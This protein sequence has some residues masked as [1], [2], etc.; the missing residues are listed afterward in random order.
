MV[1]RKSQAIWSV[2]ALSIVPT[3]VYA[4]SIKIMSQNG[5]DAGMVLCGYVGLLLVAATF[6]AVDIF[7]A[8]SVKNKFVACL[9]GIVSNAIIYYGFDY[10]PPYLRET[11]TAALLYWEYSAIIRHWRAEWFR[12][13][14]Y[15]T[16]SP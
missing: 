6:S 14:I 4:V 8:S 16:L 1:L 11:Y 7:C 15:Y 12:M 10:I 2:L 9:I 5:I 3:I 13:A